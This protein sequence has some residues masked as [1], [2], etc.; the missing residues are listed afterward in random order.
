MSKPTP[1][2]YARYNKS[3]KGRAR[4]ERYT[5]TYHDRAAVSVFTQIAA[6]FKPQVLDLNGDIF[7]LVNLSAYPQI[8]VLNAQAVADLDGEID[9]GI[10]MAKALIKAI[11]PQILHWKNG[12]HEWRLLRALSRVT[13]AGAKKIL[14]MRVM[15]KAWTY[16]NLFNFASFP[17]PV[18]FAGEYPKGMWLHPSLPPEQ[19][20]WVEHGYTASKNSGYTVTNK[21]NERGC[22]VIV[23]HCEKLAGPLWKHVVGSRNWFGIENGNL[24]IIGVPA[25]GAH[26]NGE[27]LYQGVP[28][29]EPDYMN[30]QQGFSLLTYTDGQW[31][32]YTV[33]IIKGKAHWNGKLYRG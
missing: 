17:I 22:S 32:P 11:N 14:E 7:D 1:E 26:S 8:K 13:D 31:F 15:Q 5:A 18:K 10:D 16:E 3:A 21:M 30:H 20:V 19:N 12:N 27:G 23:G 33:R 9:G 2:A 6:D 29:S 4:T 25:D 24:S 28:H